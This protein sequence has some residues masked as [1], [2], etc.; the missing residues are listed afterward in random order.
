MTEEFEVHAK[1]V[2]NALQIYNQDDVK[3]VYHFLVKK[4]HPD[5]T[6][7]DEIYFKNLQMLYN[8]FDIY[9]QSA[10][11][12]KLAKGDFSYSLN[13]ILKSC[14]GDIKDYNV[15]KLIYESL[16]EY[17]NNINNKS[18]S[19]YLTN[20]LKSIELKE[21]RVP[22]FLNY[23]KKIIDYVTSFTP[24]NLNEILRDFPDPHIAKITKQ[25][26]IQIN[27]LIQKTTITINKLTT[28]EDID[29]YLNSS[30]INNYKLIII[31]YIKE[32]LSYDNNFDIKYINECSTNLDNNLKLMTIENVYNNIKQ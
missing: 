2:L 22:L 17:S 26:I 30:F 9:I 4:L 6:N 23:Q 18:L 13:Y 10:K 32:S 21:Q 15:Q 25:A 11:D 3:K 7:G 8:F 16:I 19:L 14:N 29:N 28:K 12:I 24:N 31:S 20:V 27:E 5:N 1:I